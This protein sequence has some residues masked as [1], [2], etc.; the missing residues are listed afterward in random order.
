[1]WCSGKL[2]TSRTASD[3]IFDMQGELYWING[4]YKRRQMIKQRSEGTWSQQ[5]WSWYNHT[6][7]QQSVAVRVIENSVQHLW[8][9]HVNLRYLCMPN[10]VVDDRSHWCLEGRILSCANVCSVNF[11]Y[12][13]K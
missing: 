4:S 13:D 1:M 11:G 2:E 3:G 9:K 6:Q 8:S 10:Q 12:E 5:V 7:V